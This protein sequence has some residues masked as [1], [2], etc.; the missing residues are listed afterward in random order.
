MEQLHTYTWNILC[1][2]SFQHLALPTLS[3]FYSVALLQYCS[4][5]ILNSHMT[6]LNRIFDII[7]EFVVY[8]DKYIYIYMFN[9]ILY[10]RY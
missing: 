8:D 3:V 4:V 1:C 7:Q 5:H 9:I 2:G 10:L 6:C